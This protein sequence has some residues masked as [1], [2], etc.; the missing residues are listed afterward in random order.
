M[1]NNKAITNLFGI[2]LFFMIGFTITFF[3]ALFLHDIGRTEVLDNVDNFITEYESSQPLS[4]AMSAYIHAQPD[5]YSALTI[6]YDL[7]FLATFIFFFITS[8]Y[9]AYKTQEAGWFSFFG[10]LTLLL[11]I[12]LFV[13]TFAT[14]LTNWITQTLIEDFIGFSLNNTPIIQYYYDNLGIIN[15]IWAL[16]LIFVNKLNFN[17]SRQSEDISTIEGGV[18][19]Q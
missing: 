8:L 12:F 5:E 19:E 7:F 3:V 16:L 6:P 17:F 1:Y 13:G 18:Y 9:S 10:G 14:T 15:F 4:S 11:V 2:I